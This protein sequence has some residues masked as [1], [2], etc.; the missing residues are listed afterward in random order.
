MGYKLKTK[1]LHSI[2]LSML[3]FCEGGALETSDFS[4]LYNVSR[5]MAVYL[6]G[7]SLAHPGAASLCAITAVMA[8]VLCSAVALRSKV[9]RQNAQ[10]LLLELGSKIGNK[11]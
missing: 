8:C 5:R 4:F 3:R 7:F 10:V 11:K 9:H 2:G 1:S 6:A